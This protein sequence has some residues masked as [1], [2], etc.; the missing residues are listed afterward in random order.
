MDCHYQGRLGVSCSNILRRLYGPKGEEDAKI[1]QFR[2]YYF[3]FFAIYF[4]NKENETGGARG[5]QG[6]VNE[7]TTFVGK[8][9]LKRPPEMRRRGL[10]VS[11]KM[12]LKE[13]GREVLTGFIWLRIESLWRSLGNTVTDLR[14]P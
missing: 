3:V 4:K 11:V 2:D 7:D 6:K 9:E 14:I 1:S 8:A 13:I 5:M 10:R 12:D